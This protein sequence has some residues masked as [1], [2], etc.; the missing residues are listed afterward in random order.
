MEHRVRYNGWMTAAQLDF[1]N[2]WNQCAE[3]GDADVELELPE[4]VYLLST[5]I[6]IC[7]KLMIAHLAD[8]CLSTV[9]ATPDS[10]D[11]GSQAVDSILVSD[12]EEP[13]T[14]VID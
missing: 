3:V 9:G 10:T 1:I 11:V 4:G 6:G 14:Q 5:L 13:S 8:Q 7:R 2:K 12:D